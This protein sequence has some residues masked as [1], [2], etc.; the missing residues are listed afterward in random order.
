MKKTTLISLVAL[1]LV[2]MATAA[3]AGKLDQIKERGTLICG[4]KDAVVPFGYVDEDSKQLVLHCKQAG[5]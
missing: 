4:V 5:R 1:C 2:L 3:F